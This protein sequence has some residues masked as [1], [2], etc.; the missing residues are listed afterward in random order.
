MPRWI[1]TVLRPVLLLALPLALLLGAAAPPTPPTPPPDRAVSLYRYA[2]GLGYHPFTSP[3]QVREQLTTHFWLFPVS[4]GCAGT[5]RVGERCELLGGNPV[6][7]ESIGADY[8]RIL[9]LPGHALGSGLLIRFGFGEWLGF[10]G[11]TVEAWNTGSAGCPPGGACAKAAAV[12]A[13][14]LWRVL[15][16]IL[17]TSAYLA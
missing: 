3:Q 14:W 12:G 9:T 10:H 13:W 7:V 8:L 17:K 4:G 5:I 2:Y 11:L 6:E 15:A 1:P 16:G